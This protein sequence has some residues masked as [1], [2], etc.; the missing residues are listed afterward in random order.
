MKKFFKG[1]VVACALAVGCVGGVSCAKQPEDPKQVA[2]RVHNNEIQWHYV[3]DENWLDLISLNTLKGENGLS[4]KSAYEIAVENGFKGSEQEWLELLVGK[5]G[6]NGKSAYEIAVE[7]GFKG[8]EKEWLESLKGS[9][10]ENGSNGTNGKSAY[11]IAVENGFKGSEEDWL[12]SLKGADGKSVYDVAVENGFKGSEEDWLA[13]LKGGQ[14]EAGYTPY[15]GENGNWWIGEEDTGIAVLEKN[16]DGVG[17]D[18]LSFQITIRG[19]VA[20]YEVISYAGTETDIVIPNEIFDQPVV[21]IKAG[22]LPTS[23]TSLSISSNTEY[24]PTFSDYD[25]LTEFDFNH[26]PIEKIPA[27][28]FK[29]SSMLHTLKNYEKVT[30]I[31]AYAFN[32]TRVRDFDYSNIQTIGAYA[33]YNSGYDL[34]K[35]GDEAELL[36][37]I[38]KNNIF[39]YIPENVTTIGEKAFNDSSEFPVYYEGDTAVSYTGSYFYKNVKHDTSGYYYRDLGTSASLLNYDGKETRLKV[40]MLLGSKILSSVEKYAFFANGIVERVELPSSVE[41]IGT[42][43]F[44]YCYNLHSLFVPDSV[45]ACGKYIGS[46]FEDDFIGSEVPTVFFETTTFDYQGGV[47][48]PAELT[49]KYMIGVTPASVVDDDV[50]VYYK[51]GTYAQVVTIKNVQGTVTIPSV[52]DK[53]P[54][55]NINKYALY[56]T[57]Q[58]LVVNV[59]KSVTNI[60]SYAFGESSNLLAVNIPNADNDVNEYGFY[61]C[62]NCTVYLEAA[63][64]PENWDSSWYSGIKG[65]QVSSQGNYSQSGDYFYKLVDGKVYLVKY[66]GE[67]TDTLLVVPSI[68][69]GKE[70]YGICR[71]CYEVPS[72]ITS[73]V[74]SS[75]RYKIVIP[76][77]VQV[78]EQYAIY[79]N[80][81]NHPSSYTDVF[82]SSTSKP[83]GWNYNAVYSS[84]NGNNY[85]YYVYTGSWSMVNGVPVRN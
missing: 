80:S 43:A 45:N 11:E 57:T 55:R 44:S 14:G 76:Q 35:F 74:S 59:P 28:M 47:T 50:C 71:Y 40:P 19:G 84:Y 82:V 60:A 37:Y 32:D 66:Y 67:Y 17:T 58:T 52:I 68:I 46:R 4:G 22:A 10:G 38:L 81:S 20:G 16:M 6:V 48:S 34:D 31:G 62:S 69:D 49:E 42:T 51:K 63:S 25:N 64:V 54:V 75:N 24:L 12:A 5:D 39:V 26:A 18:G 27:G 41:S 1:L 77:S 53:L 61:S 23:M 72:K 78:M 15:I 70:V 65:Y 36:D 73:K 83:S 7:N 3:D 30:E 2:F 13:S 79:L 29:S 21:S 8:S 9:S 85:I 56:G 33:F